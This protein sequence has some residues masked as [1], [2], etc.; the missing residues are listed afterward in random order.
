MN[1]RHK[2]K[3]LYNDKPISFFQ[4]FRFAERK[5]KAMMAVGYIAALANGAALPVFSLIFGGLAKT[6]S[7][8]GDMEHLVSTAG[9]YAIYFLALGVGEFILGYIS[10][11]CGMATGERQA[12]AFRK[13]YF[14]A[15]I[16]Q[17]IGFFDTINPNE[18]ASTIAQ[19]CVDYQNGVGE[20]V[21]TFLFS[22]GMIISGFVIGFIRGW[23][24]ALVLCACIPFIVLSGTLF[25]FV[26][27]KVAVV[28]NLAYSKAGGIAEECIN[29]IRTVVAL[30]GEE[31]EKARYHQG[32]QEA[33]NKVLKFYYLAGFAIGMVFFSKMGAY[34]LGFW[35]GSVLID[36]GTTNAITGEPYDTGDV[37]AVFF[38]IL[39]GS[40]AIAQITPCLSTFADARIAAT[41]AYKIIDRKSNISVTDPRGLKPEVIEGVIEFKNVQFAYPTKPEKTI[42]NGVSF[43][44]RKNEKT[45]LVG[46]SGCG[47][48][49][50]M[51]LI[52]RFYD[53][54]GGSLTLDGNEIRE[55]NLKWLRSNIGYVGQEPVLF[56]ATI[57]ENMQ[58]AKENATDD[59]IWDALK[60]ANAEDFVRSL[61]KQLD[62][63][64]G[65]SGTQLSGG[66]KQ[67]LAI[68]R[69]ILKNPKILLLDE[70]TSAL[71]RKN[72]IEIQKTLDKI[73]EG[74]TTVVIA[75]RLTTIQN[76]DHIIVFENGNVV[77]EGKHEELVAK[78]G[79]YYDLQ[80]H[81]LGQAEQTDDLK[82]EQEDEI[83]I[84]YE[85][86]DILQDGD[87]RGETNNTLE[88]ETQPELSNNVSCRLSN[89]IQKR[90]QVNPESMSSFVLEESRMTHETNLQSADTKIMR[91]LL[92][93][94][95]EKRGFFVLAIIFAVLSGVVFPFYALIIPFMI[96]TL[97]MP[98]AEDYGSRVGRGVIYFSICAVVAL[99]TH[100]LRL[101]CFGQVAQELVLKLRTELFAKYLKMDMSFF[102]LPENTPGALCTKLAND[103]SQVRALTTT[104]ISVYIQAASSFVTGLAIAFAGDWKLGFIALGYSPIT[105][106]SSLAQTRINQKFAKLNDSAYEESGGF[107]AETVNNMRTV[108]SFGREESLIQNYDN[109]LA[110]P[111]SRAQRKANLTGLAFGFT[112]LATMGLNALIF[113]IGAIFVRESGL[114]FQGLFQAFFGVVFAA[115]GV[116]QVAQFA[117]DVGS[118]R[119]AAV[120]IFKVLDA[121]PLIDIDDPSQNVKSEITGD[122]EFKNVW[123]KYPTRPKT[124]L[125]G[126]NLKIHAS[127]KV[128]FVGPSGCGKSTVLSLLLRYYD[129]NK[130][131][132]LIDG[133][134]IQKYDLR[135]LRKSIGVVSQEPIL[136]NGTI[137]Y[138]IKYTNPD[139]SEAEMRQ[140]AE[141]ANAFSFIENNQFDDVAAGRDQDTTKFGKGFQRMVGPKGSQI[142]GGQ[143]QRIAIARAI[144]RKPKI[145]LLDEA[146]SA[147]DSQNEKIVQESLDK[148]MQ[149]KTSIVVAHRIS[150][151][152]D[153]NEICVFYNG[154]VVERG[155]YEALT[156]AE[157]M[158]YKLE[159]GLPIT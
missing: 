138:N 25:V 33:K 8:E 47:K 131:E 123:F 17:E 150:T 130:G 109:K 70:A 119:N 54:T 127:N 55:L 156:K 16:R 11:S 78:R 104:V 10:F 5:D 27:Q 14:R 151:I 136:F 124:I 135:H 52:E 107:V 137:E 140:A 113:Y 100:F 74:R 18:L 90:S 71:D 152:R 88:R 58:L 1:S 143:K 30:G 134:P 35:Y 60:N 12:I 19:Q 61:P 85:K 28:S 159:R 110:G 111:L 86:T 24:L 108:A 105:V 149:G 133:I 125:K 34:A 53:I 4:L 145:L 64:V 46:E 69:A 26:L 31:R 142:S 120:S 148:I 101:G 157:G 84:P 115:L 91:R 117:P 118:A 153:A 83:D 97:S 128:A 63:Y 6:F 59:E 49:T 72:E 43:T 146:T 75:H 112:H 92:N 141:Q 129:V 154:K 23:Q 62:T 7:P 68:A 82:D 139:A 2:R 158:F 65:A 102:D 116:S 155:T 45:A 122:I 40:Q 44:I 144:L 67:R 15:L 39:I 3:R 22:L 29:A 48:T 42:L 21:T 66:Q 95:K 13:A 98:N 79:K 103:C 106:I 89:I 32:L 20:K 76:A 57:R 9:R 80:K 50:S 126:L 36:N 96:E 41:D 73:S 51:Q 94:N 99:F 87:Q 121:K 147:L 132:I 77:E 56:A 38:S 37:L 81:Q 93:Y 114:S